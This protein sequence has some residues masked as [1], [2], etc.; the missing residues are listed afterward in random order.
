MTFYRFLLPLL[1][2][3]GW[4]AQAQHTLR[5]SVASAQNTPLDGA[6]IHIDNLHGVAS[7]DGG[8][9]LHGIGTGSHRVVISYLGYKSLDTI[10]AFDS[11]R[12]LN[13]I[14]EPESLA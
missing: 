8:Y 1:L 12:V 3:G 10:L 14:L 6:H 7:P 2:A 4:C 13:A 5:G 11:D 9:E